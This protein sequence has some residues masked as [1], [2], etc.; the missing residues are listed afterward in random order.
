MNET[1]RAAMFLGPKEMELQDDP[2]PVA[3]PGEVVLKI[4]ACAVCGTDLRIFTGGKTRGVYP[5]R[6]LGH[7]IAGVVVD[8]GTGADAFT[9]VKVGDRVATPPG[10]PC[11]ACRFCNTGHENLCKRRSALGYRF[12]GGFAEYMLVPATGVQRGLLYHIPDGL[13]D[14]EAALAEP[15]ACVVNGQRKNDIRLGGVVLVVGAG[16]IGL[17]HLQLARLQGARKVLLSEPSAARRQ[18]ATELGATRTVDPTQENLAEVVR[19]E[20]AG[21]GADVT[22]AAIGVAGLTNTLLEGTRPGG[23]VNLFAGYSGTGE[24]TLEANL[25]HYGELIVTGTNACTREDFRKAL[26]LLAGGQFKAGPLIT[27]RFPLEQIHEA[28][29]TTR[30]GA[31]LRV[32]VEP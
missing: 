24:T 25:I 17:M 7:E 3:G 22:V 21:D 20:T 14:A 32:L 23:R 6:I 9:D 2:R 18:L 31:G 15:L 13:S 27:H 26:D 28:F 10:I 1:M 12:D 19:A 29:E 16:P 8:V 5:P 4:G 30:S 11:L